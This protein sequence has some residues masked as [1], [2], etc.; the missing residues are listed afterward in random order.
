MNIDFNI[1]KKEFENEDILN[2][3]DYE[4]SKVDIDF[5]RIK[6]IFIQNRLDDFYDDKIEATNQEECEANINQAISYFLMIKMI[7]N[8]NT[9]FELIN[10]MRHAFKDTMIDIFFNIFEINIKNI[11]NIDDNKILA[12]YLKLFEKYL[13]LTKEEVEKILS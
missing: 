8:S 10:N 3:I 12:F 6:L 7:N 4:I 9:Y 2:D 13:V 5:N 11:N 1:I